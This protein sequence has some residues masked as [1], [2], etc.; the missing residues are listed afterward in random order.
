MTANTK[1][2]NPGHPP[3]ARYEAGLLWRGYQQRLNAQRQKEEERKKKEEEERKKAC[4]EQH[5]DCV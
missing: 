3:E 2:S 5:T 4:E 1:S